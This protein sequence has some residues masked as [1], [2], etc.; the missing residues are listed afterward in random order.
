M[1]VIHD[2]NSHLI[3]TVTYYTYKTGSR[4]QQV[5]STKPIMDAENRKAE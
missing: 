5:L 3:E 1:C 2:S 4:S